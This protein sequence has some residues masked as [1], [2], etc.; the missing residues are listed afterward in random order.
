MNGAPFWL[1][2]PLICVYDCL[3]RNSAVS[4]VNQINYAWA[5]RGIQLL[6]KYA[7]F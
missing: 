2:L 1:D 5:G 7:E 4:E 3:Y 6:T